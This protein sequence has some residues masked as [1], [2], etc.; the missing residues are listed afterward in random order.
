[1]KINHLPYFLLLLQPIWSGADES[2]SGENAGV[3]QSP[4][5]SLGRQ[6]QVQGLNAAIKLSN[7]ESMRRESED[8]DP[9]KR[10]SHSGKGGSGGKGGG[11]SAGGGSQAV[12]EPHS[13][14]SSDALP[15]QLLY[16][17]FTQIIFHALVVSVFV[18]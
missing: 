7:G 6:L 16:S 10:L 9:L 15:M 4:V 13:Q 12:R 2:T 14:R 5:F 17:S 18:F 1:M 8:L 11:R 3:H